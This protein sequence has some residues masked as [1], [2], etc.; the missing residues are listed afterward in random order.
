MQSGAI[1]IGAYCQDCDRR[2]TNEPWLPK[3][4]FTAEQIASMPV[5]DNYTG[6]AVCQYKDCNATGIEWNHYA[7]RALFGEDA[8]N[9]PIG[10][11]CRAHHRT[12]HTGLEKKLMRHCPKCHQVMNAAAIVD[13]FPEPSTWQFYGAPGCRFIRCRG[14]VDGRG[15]VHFVVKDGPRE[16]HRLAYGIPQGQPA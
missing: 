12:W 8:E 6:G 10:P 13:A 11:L 1:A 2:A 4:Q 9:W 15:Y 5:H 14:E 7:P 3:S 16:F